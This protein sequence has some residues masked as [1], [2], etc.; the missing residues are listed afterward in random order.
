MMVKKVIGNK[1][2]GI[3]LKND[4]TLQELSDRSGVS[5][6]MISRIERGLTIPSVEILVKLAQALEKSIDYFVEELSTT[7]EV[8]YTKNGNRTRT[9]YE[10][11]KNMLTESFTAGLRDPQFTAF[12]C[13]VKQGSCSGIERM[14]H[15]GDELIF[16]LEGELHVSIGEDEYDLHPGDSLSFK[17]HLPHR[18]ENRG[19]KDA[20]VVWT[21]SPFTT[22]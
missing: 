18:W 4:Y 5:P 8:V 10:N 15:P 3:R 20:R 16:V 7:H 19:E 11:E 22:L 21:L 12:L 6:N 13:T 17:S 9:V 14:Y 1:L 2:K